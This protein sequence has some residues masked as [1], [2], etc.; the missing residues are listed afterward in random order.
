MFVDNLFSKINTSKSH[1]YLYLTPHVYTVGDCSTEILYGIIKAKSR[2]KKLFIIY[3][4]DIPFI[5]RWKLT[6]NELFLLE[7]K[8]IVKQGKY[9][10]LM[11]RLLAT[12]VYVPIRIYGLIAR[13]Y[14]GKNIDESVS[15]PRI[16]EREVYSPINGENIYNYSLTRQYVSDWWGRGEMK[17]AVVG[18]HLQFEF[19]S[20]NSLKKTLGMSENDWYVCLHVRE[21]G[22]RNDKDRRE[23]RNSNI[24]NYIKAIR[25]ITLRGGWVIRMGDNTMTRLPKMERVIDYPFTYHKSDLNDLLLIKY[26]YFYIGNQS[27]ILDTA[28][29]FSKNV[30]IINMIDWSASG[31]YGR[32][33]RGILK[34][35]YS[36]KEKKYVS[37]EW[38]FKNMV[39]F[40]T[41]EYAMYSNSSEH[42]KWKGVHGF[43]I[44][45][46]DYTLVEN[47]EDEIKDA[48]VEYLDMLTSDDYSPSNFQSLFSMYRQKCIENILFDKHKGVYMFGSDKR[49]LI[50]NNNFS[51]R[52]ELSNG[53]I[54]N[55]FL[56]KNWSS[57]SR[58]SS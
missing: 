9:V 27:G 54:S 57:N 34:H 29:L 8:Y 42:H 40:I 25:E 26:C 3:P 31:L 36:K 39:G 15:I 32:Y 47:S 43:P 35:W 52:T 50:N 1:R 5:F 51:F 24:R 38:L 44:S 17:D 28:N 18:L 4:Y 37:L 49:N 53:F 20:I 16:G 45:M 22:F 2:K 14:F 48:V 58:N 11:V 56:S 19:N 7:S 33:A 41:E 55:C 21:N 12:L 46:E 30:L 6:N 10:R 23:Y 13:D